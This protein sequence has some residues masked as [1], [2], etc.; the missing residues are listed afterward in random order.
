MLEDRVIILKLFDAIKE[1]IYGLLQ[2][3]YPLLLYHRSYLKFYRHTQGKDRC[4]LTMA[5]HVKWHASLTDIVDHSRGS[6]YG[7]KVLIDFFVNKYP[8]RQLQSAPLRQ[9]YLL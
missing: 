5:E 6:F 1:E 4:G 7:M 3:E 8:R 2:N 9:R